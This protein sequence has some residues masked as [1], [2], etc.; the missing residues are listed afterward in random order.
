MSS[1]QLTDLANSKGFV[2]DFKTPD[3]ENYR[4][5]GENYVSQDYPEGM[6]DILF[7]YKGKLAY[8]ININETKEPKR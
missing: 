5:V 2:L 1:A 3:L 6:Y 7:T 8:Y 4:Y